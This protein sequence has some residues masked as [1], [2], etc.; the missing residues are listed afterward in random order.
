MDIAV[1]WA[2]G[3]LGSDLDARAVD[4]EARSDGDLPQ[5]DDRWK[6]ANDIVW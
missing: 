4:Y 3:P 6:N 1:S 5:A 2:D